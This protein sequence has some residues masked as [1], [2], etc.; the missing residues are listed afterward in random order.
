MSPAH[1]FLMI[2]VI[3]LCTFFTR[4]IPFALFGG[5]KG[6]PPVIVYL[7][8]YLPPAMIATLIVY[9]LKNVEF[10][11][12]P[13]GIPELSAVALVALLHVWK[14]NNLLS[15]GLGTAF[16]MILVQFVF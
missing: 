12:W 11:R 10:T 9:C 5:E 6:V 15:I 14:R 13:S 7:G 2:A 16:Y 8:K 4:L 3:A 1:T